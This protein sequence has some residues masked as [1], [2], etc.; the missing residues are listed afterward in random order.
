[1]IAAQK[2]GYALDVSVSNAVRMVDDTDPPNRVEKRRDIIGRKIVR[3]G[4]HED[5]RLHRCGELMGGEVPSDRGAMV[6]TCSTRSGS[7]TS[8]LPWR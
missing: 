7:G 2:L 6:L 4:L 3:V 5:D 1:M 8:R